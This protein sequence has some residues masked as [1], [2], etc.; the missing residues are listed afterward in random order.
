MN[1]ESGFLSKFYL[2]GLTLLDYFTDN[3]WVDRHNLIRR[4][5]KTNVCHLA[6][7]FFAIPFM[8]LVWSVL[9]AYGV[10]V[11]LY[12]P[13]VVF[14]GAIGYIKAIGWISVTLVGVIALFIGVVGV[15]HTYDGIRGKL[16]DRSERRKHV[17]APG[18]LA[19]LRLWVRDRKEKVC[20]TVYLNGSQ[21]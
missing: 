1:L 10:F 18:L 17:S 11:L 13:T 15:V 12:Y 2:F 3:K 5:N 4:W 6:G 7:V 19:V 16:K 20:T 14:D 21:S 8:V 9:Y